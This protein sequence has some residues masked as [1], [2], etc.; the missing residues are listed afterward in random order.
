MLVSL[1]L[2]GTGTLALRGQPAR[3]RV[4]SA[5]AQAA[6][7][8]CRGCHGS[9]WRLSPQKASLAQGTPSTPFS[10]IDANCMRCHQGLPNPAV[11]QGASKLPQWSGTG[12]SHI[13]G[14]FLERAKNFS[15]L[16]TTA[17]N[18][19][20]LVKAQC[21]GCHDSHAKDRPAYLA[22]QAFD[23]FGKPTKVRATS[24]AQVCFTC[25]AG[26]EAVRTL[27]QQGD[28]GILFRPEAASSHRPGAQAAMRQDLPSLRPGLFKGSL[29]CT[30]CHDNPKATSARGPH[31]SPYPHLLKAAFGR[32][33]EV[34]SVGSHGNDLCF[35]CHDRI[36]IMGNQSFPWHAQ[37]IGG[38][39]PETQVVS[40]ASRTAAGPRFLSPQAPGRMSPWAGL[41]ASAGLGKPAACATCH[42]SHGSA[43]WPAL[44]DFDPAVVSRASLGVLDYQRMGLGH[45]SCTLSCH[46]HDH[47]QTR[48]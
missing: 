45:G 3:S 30:S 11:D 36:S 32:E 43:R 39:T 42:N 10:T 18:R 1:L 40:K 27:K 33:S 34:A 9:H 20:V 22:G 7:G 2:A 24:V 35:T 31:G 26:P 15:K 46:G 5:K 19:K 41:A 21:S 37:H 28:L 25:H 17:S 44:L 48:Y 16:V 12:S 38:F 4:P 6:H 13:D 14:P 29:D 8:N 23:A 47:L